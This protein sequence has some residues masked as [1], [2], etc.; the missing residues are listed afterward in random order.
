MHVG[1]KNSFLLAP[2]VGILLAQPHDGAQRL[3]VEA[4]CLGLGVDVANIVADRFFLFL[5]LFDALDES[6]QVIFCK[7]NGR[8]CPA[9]TRL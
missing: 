2:F 5:Q 3:D 4:V 6:F 1:L 9:L 8:S 7:T